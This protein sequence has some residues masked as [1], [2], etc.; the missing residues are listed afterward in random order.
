[1]SAIIAGMRVVAAAIVQRGRLL[2][3]SKK[4]A[5]RVFFLPGGKAEAGEDEH[6]TLAR[7]L[8]EELGVRPVTAEP[9]MIVEDLS[10]L[11][12]VPMR[13]SVFSVTIGDTPR[14]AAELSAMAWT[15]GRDEYRP[16]LAPALHDH[17]LPRLSA[18]GL[19]G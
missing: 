16:L 7:E 4:S 5:E 8:G 13:M 12:R 1:M 9:L 3:V 11:E 15:D 2:V 6:A 18:V 19:L 17:V 14:P 10:A